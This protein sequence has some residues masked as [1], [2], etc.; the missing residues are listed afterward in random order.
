M[1]YR[2][3]KT[4]DSPPVYEEIDLSD[5]APIYSGI[6]G[7]SDAGSRRA[8]SCWSRLRSYTR[9]CLLAPQYAI[10]LATLVGVAVFTAST[11]GLVK[12]VQYEA[13]H[14]TVEEDPMYW[15]AAAR[16][17]Y[18]ICYN[19]CGDSVNP[20][21]VAEACELTTRL[22]VPGAVC[23]ANKM[24]NWADRY[25]L[26][27]LDS[28]G[29]LL[30]SIALEDARANKRTL[31]ALIPLVLAAS[32]LL[33]FG[34]YCA[35]KKLTR[36]SRTGLGMGNGGGTAEQPILPDNNARN[37]HR[38]TR[39]GK[40]KSFFTSSFALCGSV[41]AVPCN[42]NGVVPYDQ[43]F[44]SNGA[45]QTSI[46]GVVHA[47]LGDC[48]MQEKCFQVCVDECDQ[49]EPPDEAY[50]DFFDLFSLGKSP[51]HK[52]CRRFC[53]ERCD[54]DRAV[55]IKH[56]RNYI[57]DVMQ[58]VRACGFETHGTPRPHTD[59]ERGGPNTV[60]IA[61]AM[62]EKYWMV[63]IRVSGL[64]VTEPGKTDERVTCLHGIGGPWK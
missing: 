37:G 50:F 34:T 27:C 9:Q 54:R 57:D 26:A 29:Q 11:Y 40:L 21:C 61:N 31:L 28:N 25:P 55:V 41:R 8:P 7:T 52:S 35:W 4:Q 13:S 60:R 3:P 2:T 16:K 51:S 10:P 18:D 15:Q 53:H 56:P 64:N 1:M 20:G 30:K 43:Y 12:Y 58:H 38:R 23:D 47:W 44:T 5:P 36:R 32:A 42:G 45:F 33:G 59:V 62:L 46:S 22:S 6:A 14:V 17:P 49:N 39:A 63:T 19:G 24:W 48:M